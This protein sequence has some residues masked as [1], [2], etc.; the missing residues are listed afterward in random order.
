MLL[1]TVGRHCYYV[2]ITLRKFMQYLWS[3]LTLSL[4]LKPI[5]V[6]LRTVKEEVKFSYLKVI[7]SDPSV[8]YSVS[9]DIQLLYGDLHRP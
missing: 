6:K 4:P 7:Y 8:I 3:S 9:D 2:D 1:H 5:E